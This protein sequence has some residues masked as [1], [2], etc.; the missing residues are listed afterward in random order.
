MIWDK[1]HK[2]RDKSAHE[3]LTRGRQELAK[4]QERLLGKGCAELSDAQLSKML[5]NAGTLNDALTAL[6]QRMRDTPRLTPAFTQRAE[7]VRLMRERF[8]A[9]T[10]RLISQA[11]D[12]SA[13]RFTIFEQTFAFD[14]MP[15]WHVEPRSGKRTPLEHWSK[16]DYLNPDFAGDKKFT[17]ELSRHQFLVTLGQAYWLTGDEKYAARFVELVNDWI[18]KNPPKQGINWA[19]S[20][21][22]AFRVIAWLWALHYFADAPSV[23]NEFLKRMLKSLIQQTQHVETYLSLYF[24]PNTHL[25]G[26]ALALLYVGTALP[27]L[28]QAEHWRAT[29]RDILLKHLPRHV[30]R[31]GVYF[32][33]ASYYHRYT[34]DFYAHLWLLSDEVPTLVKDK[35]AGLFEHLMW[36]T[37][38]DGGA[39]FYGDDDG[40]KLLWL[41]ARKTDDWRD[42]LATGAAVFNRS[43][44]KFV[45][46][47]SSELLWLAGAESWQ[48]YDALKTEAPTAD[49]KAF[50][51]SGYY[52]M[53]DG[54]QDEAS[55]VWIDSGK[56][57]AMNCG[58]AHSD[59]LSFE[60]AAAGATWLVDPGTFTYTGDLALRNEI[61][62][63]FSHSTVSVDGETQ[64]VP[65]K[66][67]TWRHT[68]QS[69][70]R[71]CRNSDAELAVTGQQN[72]YVRLSD[73]V[74]QRRSFN[75]LKKNFTA[76]D[77]T[78][79][80]IRDEMEAQAAHRY[81][82]HFH[83]APDCVVTLENET[84]ARV[85][86][87]SGPSEKMLY[88]NWQPGSG[89]FLSE[90]DWQITPGW[91]SRCYG[92]RT[93]AQVLTIRFEA[94]GDVTWET[95]F[96]AVGN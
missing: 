57:G 50:V 9:E 7:I 95:V 12:V 14:L 29:G 88:V 49:F 82:V 36:I 15:D 83:F 3:W 54:W 71:E 20:L 76:S 18:E 66:A 96:A 80:V 87:G 47:E 37:R 6:C 30:G 73:P 60:F 26:E 93:A 27:E 59:A 2:L 31:D 69:L 61:R 35:L 21:E 91:V 90:A 5:T 43:D 52:V 48:V 45:A 32:E 86:H 33:Q 17:W 65:D 72:G 68:A 22:L 25:T 28:R 1:L 89:K 46:G 23:T 41:S 34:T 94:T 70:I 42:T 81:A 39:T 51:E 62:S 4:W 58:H 44:W 16:L 11:D 19:S 55:Y 79:L 13:G 67:F 56:H 40:G 78:R 84:Q 75:L 53:R 10:Q 77:T 74:R 8:P 24:S 92:Q 85:I 64:S 63:S 38:P